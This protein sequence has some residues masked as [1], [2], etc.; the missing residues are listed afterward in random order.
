MAN[1]C[2]LIIGILLALAPGC[3]KAGPTNIGADGSV[4][5]LDFE[6]PAQRSQFDDPTRQEA[7]GFGYGEWSVE[8]GV[9][10][11]TKGAA[12]NLA[13]HLRYVGGAFGEK[14]GKAPQKYRVAVDVSAY[15]PTESPQVHGSPTGVLAFMPYYKD[16][17]H[18]VILVASRHSIEAWNVDGLRAAGEA[19]PPEARL[20]YEYLPYE[21]KVGDT[22]HWRAEVD[23][24]KK[25]IRFWYGDDEKEKATMAIP[26]LDA[27]PHYVTLAANG[28]FVSFDNLSLYYLEAKK[29]GILGF[30]GL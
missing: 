8:A 19:W 4:G 12:D 5:K 13:N 20:F 9:L 23:V 6:D 1:R 11:Q 18:Y 17:T 2:A 28:N 16:P 3:G 26:N 27:S 25:S 24:P 21:V 30:L 10:K 15:Q 14:G 29:Q 22:V 7:S